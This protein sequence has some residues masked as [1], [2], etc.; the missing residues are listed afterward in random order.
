MMTTLAYK[1]TVFEKLYPVQKKVNSCIKR[2][3]TNLGEIQDLQNLSQS[4]L[5]IKN[6]GNCVK[7]CRMVEEDMLHFYRNIDFMS[8]FKFEFCVKGCKKGSLLSQRF[9]LNNFE[10][11]KEEIACYF[12]CW[13]RLDRRYRMYWKDK[14]DDILARYY[15]QGAFTDMY[16]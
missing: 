12:S 13:S 3:Y 1:D 14:R 8:I 15:G 9:N 5:K 10:T 11:R 16:N 2:C 6:L 4:S 7:G